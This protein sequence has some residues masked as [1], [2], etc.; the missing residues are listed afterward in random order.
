MPD[1]NWLDWV[2]LIIL[3]VSS[4]SAFSK[5]F[6]RVII[7]IVTSV[8]AIIL[9]MWFYGLAGSFYSTWTESEH[10]Q[11]LLGFITVLVAVWITGGLL[12]WLIHRFLRTAGLSWLDRLL[13]L[14]FGLVRGGL[15]CMAILTAYMSFGVKPG[16]KTVPATVLHSRIAPSILQASR[17]FVALAPMDL[18]QSFQKHYSEAEASWLERA[19]NRSKAGRQPKTEEQ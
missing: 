10:V 3:A 18:K 19:T 11:H 5:G 15:V 1:F 12:G 7:G 16:E 9:A 4:L 14:A 13:G 8:A 6:S 2:L 17:L